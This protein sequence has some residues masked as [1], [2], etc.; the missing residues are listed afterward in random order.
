MSKFKVGDKVEVVYRQNGDDDTDGDRPWVKPGARCIVTK[1]SC[2][3]DDFNNQVTND[4]GDQDWLKDDQLK[5]VESEPRKDIPKVGDRVRVVLEGEV[6]AIGS[7]RPVLAVGPTWARQ[8]VDLDL[9]V[10]TSVEVIEPAKPSLSDL[11]LGTVIQLATTSVLVK[12]SNHEPQWKTEDGVWRTSAG[13]R[14]TWTV[15]V[16]KKDEE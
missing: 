9:G 14:D 13:V 6:T 3:Y 8:L 10:V 1:W 15:L 7:E 11:P 4:E 5:L 16:P 12:R 2:N